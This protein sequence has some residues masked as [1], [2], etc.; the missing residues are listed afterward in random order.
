MKALKNSLFF[1]L[2]FINSL[3]GIDHK[4]ERVQ[5]LEIIRH[6]LQVSYAP[7]EWKKE[8]NAFDLDQVFREAKLE[9]AKQE[10]LTTK[11]FQ[12]IV[13]KVLNKLQDCHVGMMFYSTEKA[14]LPFSIRGIEGRYFIDWID[15]M[16]LS[17]S[18]YS[19][20]MGDELL[21]FDHRPIQEVMDELLLLCCNG[22]N[23]STNN[24]QAELNLTNR[25]GEMGDQ[26][27]QGSIML[28]FRTKE[29]N[30][31]SCQMHWNY[32]PESIFNLFDLPKKSFLSMDRE[33]ER[34]SMMNPACKASSQRGWMGSP[35]SFLP[36]FGEPTWISEPGSKWHAYVY[37]HP[38]G[39]SVG[40]IRIPHYEDSHPQAVAFGEILTILEEKS[41]VLVIDQLHNFG[42]Y[43]DYMYELASMLA[44]EPMKAPY[45]RIK[46]T[47]KD[48]MGAYSL[49]EK[50]KRD[51]IV[52]TVFDDPIKQE[53]GDNNDTLPSNHQQNLFLKSFYEFILSEWNQ[54]FHLT[55]PTPILGVDLINPHPKYRYTKPILFLI[56]EMDFSGGD[57][58][59][60]ILQDNGRAILFGSKT[61]GAGGYVKSFQF[62]NL[63]GMWRCSYTASIAERSCTKK[64][65]NL[66]VL[67]DIEYQL[68]AEDLQDHYKGYVEA[69]NQALHE[70]FRE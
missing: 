26:V 44:I 19:I 17:P 36:Y 54:G 40:Y 23:E 22:S 42:G 7:L 61:A 3:R 41:D 43:V 37:L 56:D 57:F 16:E 60:A 28:T 33:N 18:F 6:H 2:F 12:Q 29:G 63:N 13:R 52:R 66:G 27:P 15:Q 32:T 39:K 68:T 70:F 35:T 50:M 64:I 20:G 46:I 34:V 47:Q 55:A 25:L 10:A 30:Q 59:P 14:T 11:Q 5:D 49:L 69:V 8:S 48:A 4:R 62:P 65:E 45:H 38:S 53:S 31:K 9:I 67:P 21:Q 51:E 58:M 24:R 1:S